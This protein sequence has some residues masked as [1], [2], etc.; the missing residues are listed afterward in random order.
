MRRYAFYDE[1]RCYRNMRKV[2]Y[3]RLYNSDVRIVKCRL[4]DKE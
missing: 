1:G 4:R 2:L 3:F